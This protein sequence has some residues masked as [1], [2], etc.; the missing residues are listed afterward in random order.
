MESSQNATDYKEYFYNKFITL[1]GELI[2]FCSYNVNR[3]QNIDD[4]LKIKN[5]LSKL[6]YVKIINKLIDNNQIRESLFM[7]NKYEFDDEHMSKLVNSSD[8]YWMIIPSFH[9]NKILMDLK[10]EDQILIYEKLNNLYIC[11]CTYKKVIDQIESTNNEQEFNPFDSV[12]SNLISENMDIATLFNGVETKN[13][14]AYEMLMETIINQQM[15]SKMTDYM[16]NIQEDDVNDAATKL[17]DVINSDKFQ[18][19]K[20][21]SQILGDMLNNIKHEVL[22]LKSDEQKADGRQSVEQLLGIAQKVAGG[23]MGTIQSNN[24][25]VLDLWDATSSLAKSTTNSDALNI[26]DNLIRSNIEANIKKN[27][28]GNII[29]IEDTGIS[30]SIIEMNNDTDTNTETNTETNTKKLKRTKRIK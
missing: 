24:I 19:N 12:G 5:V 20:Q 17:H 16:N 25:N 9:I 10:L 1:F 6:D 14:S 21:T 27:N 8:K 23:M 26:V 22:N 11:A 7:L 18:G 4:L 15:D 13:I 30:S 3:Q 29:N 28:H 2:N